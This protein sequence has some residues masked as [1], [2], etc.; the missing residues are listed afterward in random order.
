MVAIRMSYT[1][2]KNLMFINVY[3]I[4]TLT[5]AGKIEKRFHSS[6]QKKRTE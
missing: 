4:V 1:E 6:Y 2:I 3:I 5:Q